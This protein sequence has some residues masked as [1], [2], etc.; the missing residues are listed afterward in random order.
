MNEIKDDKNKNKKVKIV[1]ICS[2]IEKCNIDEISKFLLKNKKS[3][4]DITIRQ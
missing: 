4:P 3:F 1:D 2:L